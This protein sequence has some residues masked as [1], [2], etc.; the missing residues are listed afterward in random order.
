MK[1]EYVKFAVWAVA[2]IGVVTLIALDK[3]PPSTLQY[4][5]FWVA[6]A[7]GARATDK[8]GNGIPDDQEGK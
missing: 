7:M 5:L 8:D 4:L 6:G 2:F 1:P 3:V